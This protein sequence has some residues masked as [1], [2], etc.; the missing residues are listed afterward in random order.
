MPGSIRHFLPPAGVIAIGAA[1]AS[2]T[3]IE[4]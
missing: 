3:L 2:S 4:E 1:V